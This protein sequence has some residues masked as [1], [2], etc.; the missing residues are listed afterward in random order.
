M[1]ESHPAHSPVCREKKLTS[2]KVHLT[3]GKMRKNLSAGLKK[4]HLPRK[5]RYPDVALLPECG[6]TVSS[7]CLPNRWWL[8]YV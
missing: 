4:A 8:K 7:A 6:P 3:T 1:V 5:R 2:E